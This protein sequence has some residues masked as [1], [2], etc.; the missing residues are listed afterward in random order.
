MPVT[1]SSSV[2]IVLSGLGVTEG[3]FAVQLIGA[4][5]SKA[6]P[7]TSSEV[8]VSSSVEPGYGLGAHISRRAAAIL[9][10]DTTEPAELALARELQVK[11]GRTQPA[12]VL[13]AL[14]GGSWIAHSQWPPVGRQVIW[15]HELKLGLLVIE[16]SANIRQQ[17]R[18]LRR[19]RAAIQAK[20]A[21][22]ERLRAASWLLALR[23]AAI[24]EV[25]ALSYDRPW[26]A[27]VAPSLPGWL[28][29]EA[30][31][32]RVGAAGLPS[33][34]GAATLVLATS[35]SSLGEALHEA[36]LSL[37]AHATSCKSYKVEVAPV[38]EQQQLKEP[39]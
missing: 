14:R 22:D 18:V 38:R 12:R 39:A 32:R 15:P 17:E 20:I 7:P 4:G 30:S 16:Y 24:D 21:A 6:H 11:S 27:E 35:D 34:S 3:L 13:A 9:A 8:E 33:I 31:L 36:T 1:S 19:S 37:N 25:V 28:P 10:A 2:G 29:M 5:E 23:E 26:A